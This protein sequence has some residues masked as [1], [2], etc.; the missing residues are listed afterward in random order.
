[1]TERF[2]ASR[3][4]EVRVDSHAA[5]FPHRVV[6]AYFLTA[7]DI[8]ILRGGLNI[9]GHHIRRKQLGRG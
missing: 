5:E 4:I 8:F 9:D 3:H 7:S 1:M 6:R 2:A